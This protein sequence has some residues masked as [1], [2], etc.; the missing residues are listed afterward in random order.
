MHKLCT[1]CNTPYIE[2]CMNKNTGVSRN[3]RKGII[4]LSISLYYKEIGER[5]AIKIIKN[6]YRFSIRTIIPFEKIYTTYQQLFSIK[7]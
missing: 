6:L 1:T 5:V 7:V 4:L 2:L 3:N